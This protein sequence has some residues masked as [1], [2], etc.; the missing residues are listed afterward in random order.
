MRLTGLVTKGDFEMGPTIGV[1]SF[2]RVYV[3]KHVASGKIWAIKAISKAECVR[4]L[5]AEHVQSERAIL[6]A[7]EHPF[8]IGFGGSFQGEPAPLRMF[9]LREARSG[10]RPAPPA[11]V[12]WP[13]PCPP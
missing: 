10:G 11:A 3:A 4:L 12:R 5:Q 2:S 7:N 9:Q 8:I 6:S 1:G 13:A